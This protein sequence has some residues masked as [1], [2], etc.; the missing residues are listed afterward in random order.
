MFKI[1]IHK[2]RC[3]QNLELVFNAGDITLIKGNSG[4]GKSTILQAITWC[5]FGNVVKCITPHNEPK[6][7]TKVTIEHGNVNIT[8]TRNPNILTVFYEDVLHEDDEAQEIINSIFSR[9]DLWLCSSYVPQN[10]RNSFLTSP[11]Q[12]KTQLLRELAFRD[13]DPKVI[14]ETIDKYLINFDTKYKLES[15]IFNNNF[16]NFENDLQ[17]Q[18]EDIKTFMENNTFDCYQNEL[19][20]LSKLEIEKDS[21]EKEIEELRKIED[22]IKFNKSVMTMLEKDLKSVIS[23][24]PVCTVLEDIYDLEKEIEN[25]E[26]FLPYLD[27]KIELEREIK[28][29]RVCQDDI[30]NYTIEDLSFTENLEK[31]YNDNFQICKKLNVKYLEK[32]VTNKITSMEKILENQIV[33]DKIN[34][35]VEKD[36][37]LVIPKI[38]KIPEIVEKIFTMPD[39]N[40]KINFSEDLERN[41][42]KV[43]EL[44]T[45][46]EN[47]K[48]GLNVLICP[49]CNENLKLAN[50]KLLKADCAPSNE[51]EINSCNREIT[52]IKNKINDNIKKIKLFD[53]EVKSYH[54][55]ILDEE[56]RLNKL[57][58]EEKSAKLLLE[59]IE[60]IKSEKHDIN[61]EI[62]KLKETFTD[63]NFGSIPLLKPAERDSYKNN[64]FLLNN[65]KYYELPIITSSEIKESFKNKE[66]LVVLN[67]LKNKYD[68]C[69]KKIGDFSYS[70]DEC[71]NIIQKNRKNIKLVET[72]SINMEDWN[73]NI[74]IINK[75]IENVVIHE[76]TNISQLEKDLSNLNKKI[77]DQIIK[78]DL[79]Q[80]REE[81]DIRY[82]ELSN[83]YIKINKLKTLKQ[84][85]VES[86]YQTL[87]ETSDTINAILSE[88]CAYLFTDHIEIE[89]NMFKNNKS[90]NLQKAMINFGINYQGGK[91]DSVNQ[92]SGGEGDRASLALT[93]SLNKILCSPILMFD[94]SLASL[95]N[96]MKEIAIKSIRHNIN[97]DTIVIVIMHDGIEGI[98]DEIIDIEDIKKE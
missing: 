34:K 74:A 10:N 75:K 23:K 16:S 56:K 71:K 91:Y 68:E 36:K 33:I 4:G 87:E 69:I 25:I 2:F 37:K 70:L 32:D 52:L 6:A 53:D 17:N 20:E 78:L 40:I 62:S 84:K 51:D 81:F 13:E 55:N 93:L 77:K 44:E 3:W 1:T 92:L 35:L 95:D 61:L 96:N 8:R 45:K 42:L 76:S 66:K 47:Y 21:L 46:L 72:F 89:V 14:I 63:I 41:R 98:Y 7:K 80:K 24:K 22:D 64:I 11:N 5:L 50:K 26:K 31:N 39:E 94:E 49:C 28:K 58:E 12:D 15:G 59:K 57:R 29:I 65:I 90:N 43:T 9:Y 27:Q 86:E 97:D 83:D 48:N 88:I 73:N 38:P 85:A 79:L 30:K 60:E 19:E 67:N 18:T 82:S 54:R